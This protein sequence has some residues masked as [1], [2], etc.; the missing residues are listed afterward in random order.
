M[1]SK[2][3]QCQGT[4]VILVRHGQSTYNALGLYQ[5]SSDIPILTEAGYADACKTG[6]FLAG[7][8][9]DCVYFSSLQRAQDTALEILDVIA[10]GTNNIFI[11]IT[12]QLRETDLPAWEGLAFK[13]VK[14]NFP[15]EYR[16]W[17]QHP[18]E[19]FMEKS[20][21]YFYPALDLYQRVQEF[22]QEVL[23]RHMGKTLLIVAHGGTNRALISTALGIPPN[24]Y[25][26]IQQSNCGIS[27]LHFPDG[28]LASGCLEA[29]NLASHVGEDIPKLQEG[30]KGLRLFL[31]ISSARE[32]QTEKLTQLLQ[33]VCIDFSLTITDTS[34]EIVQQL[35]QYHPH[36]VQLQVSREDLP[37]VVQKII[38]AK[39]TSNSQQLI[40]G[41]VVADKETIQR[42][43]AQGIGLNSSE[44]SRLKLEEGTISCIQYPGS[45]H[46]PILQAMNI[47]GGEKA[48][49]FIGV[50]RAERKLR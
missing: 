9:F 50:Q 15:D 31:V 39:N 47:S 16:L 12:Y 10:S 35:L 2:L 18:H 23:P 45:H 41:L 27:V 44:I 43:I 30:G 8:K 42:Q 49:D 34:Q 19:F 33:D 48:S 7:L 36:T 24:H 32:E 14:E 6:E 1:H 4:R 5:G 38:I 46:P 25:H 26:C 17:K 20:Q 28:S 40:T 22:W 11:N 37:E 29:M 21:R 13:Y 3:E